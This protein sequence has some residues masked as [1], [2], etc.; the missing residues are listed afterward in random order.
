MAKGTPLR[1]R[2]SRAGRARSCALSRSPR[3]PEV[4]RVSVAYLGGR[5]N[6]GAWRSNLA[7]LLPGRAHAET[8]SDAH[9]CTVET[10]AFVEEFDAE[11][12]YVSPRPTSW[13]ALWHPDLDGVFSNG[14]S[15]P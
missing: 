13:H 3:N 6:C 10:D 14:P 4:R 9:L 8:L 5:E 2:G 12:K 11:L 7:R 1:G 15:L